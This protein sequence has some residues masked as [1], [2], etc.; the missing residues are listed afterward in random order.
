MLKMTVSQKLLTGR[1]FIAPRE[2]HSC[3]EKWFQCLYNSF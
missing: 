2:L 3:S 1:R